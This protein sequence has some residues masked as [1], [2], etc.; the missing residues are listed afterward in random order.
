MGM[1][2]GFIRVGSF[3]MVAGLVLGCLTAFAAGRPMPVTPRR[4]VI[5]DSKRAELMNQLQDYIAKGVKI[6]GEELGEFRFV[7]SNDVSKE[8]I[9]YT[10]SVFA[11]LIG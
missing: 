11:E 1:K 5:S 10:L 2:R 6:N 8:D 3:L 4:S 7:T 9:D